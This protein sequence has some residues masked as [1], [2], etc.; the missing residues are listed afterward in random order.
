MQRTFTFV[1]VAYAFALIFTAMLFQWSILTLAF[2]TLAGLLLLFLGWVRWEW[3]RRGQPVAESDP[4]L[5]ARVRAACARAGRP[6]LKPRVVSGAGQPYLQLRGQTVL[7]SPASG[8]LLTDAELTALILDAL[9][10]SPAERRRWL[11]RF[12]GPQLALLA[13][14]TVISV[15]TGRPYVLLALWV[16]GLVLMVLTR[17]RL[18]NH[19]TARAGIQAFLDRGGDPRALAGALLKVYG[20]LWRAGHQRVELSTQ[21]RGLVQLLAEMGGVTPE[22]LAEIGREAEAPA[23]LY[24][25]VPAPGLAHRRSPY[26]PLVW[27]GVYLLG[28]I[29]SLI[30]VNRLSNP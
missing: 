26:R 7:I 1:G 14:F 10:F 20:A 19:R 17:R 5:E 8:R 24:R 2:V 22:E 25:P 15:V 11:W 16:L 21:I 18:V 3:Y 9:S 30:V 23:E 6:D 27:V 28:L 29:I 4:E 12:L 13:I